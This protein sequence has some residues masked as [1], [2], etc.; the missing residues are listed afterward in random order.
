VQDHQPII[1]RSRV[2]SDI[3]AL[4]RRVALSS[5]AVLITGE[6]GTGKELIARTI[7][8]SSPARTGRYIPVNVSAIPRDLVESQLFGHT[9]GAFTGADHD[10]L[11]AFRAAE[12]GT[13]LLDEIGELPLYTQPKLLRALEQ[14]EVLPVGADTPV[15]VETRVIAATSRDLD[16][17]VAH[18][19]FRPD[20]L[21][22]LNVIQIAIPPLR[23]RPED[24]P[25][26]AEYYCSRYSRALGK[27]DL[28]I[29]NGAMQCLLGHSWNGNVREL[30][31]IMERAV[32]LC[33]G[34][35]V[36]T[37]DLPHGLK[38][39][40]A[41][42]PENLRDAVETFKRQHIVKALEAVDGDRQAAARRLGLSPATLFRYIDRY[43]L[44]GYALDGGSAHSDSCNPPDAKNSHF[45]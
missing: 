39:R 26:L 4:A 15:E 33:E 14:H 24:I 7:H 21:F 31:H 12:G 43:R 22:R 20:L 40:G 6:S 2:F 25:I 5:C 9:R 17:L 8:D 36:Q 37:S 28:R 30:S 16:Q 11:G 23:E 10:R 34:D 45:R 35:S 29:S 1:A 13:L 3:M 41:K 27:P 19:R 42:A 18:H 32:L 38:P 44:K